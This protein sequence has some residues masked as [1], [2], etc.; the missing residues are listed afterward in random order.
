MSP[1]CQPYPPTNFVFEAS[2]DSGLTVN[3]PTS[4]LTDCSSITNIKGWFDPADS[5]QVTYP[6]V[7]RPYQS[8][9]I[10]FGVVSRG[11]WNGP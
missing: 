10:L 5:F 3:Y 9:K 6:G 11:S 2:S 4:T 1:N 7:T 8:I